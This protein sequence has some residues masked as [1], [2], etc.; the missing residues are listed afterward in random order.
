LAPVSKAK[1]VHQAAA[2]Q[3]RQDEATACAGLT[4]AEREIGP[5]S[6]MS[7]VGVD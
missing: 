4:T 7:V 3:L 1:S 5:L 2:N 6:K